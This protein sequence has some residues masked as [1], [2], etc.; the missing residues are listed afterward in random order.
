MSCPPPAPQACTLYVYLPASQSFVA[1]RHWPQSGC[2]GQVHP[3]ELSASVALRRARMR[4]GPASGLGLARLHCPYPFTLYAPAPMQRHHRLPYS[5]IPSP[6][7]C[8]PCSARLKAAQHVSMVPK[9]RSATLV[10]LARCST[11]SQPC[12]TRATWITASHAQHLPTTTVRRFA[13][14]QVLGLGWDRAS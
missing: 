7:P 2:L 10:A 9:A 4:H 3:G 1:V 13:L 11:S 5:S 12:A 8:L 6:S 14:R